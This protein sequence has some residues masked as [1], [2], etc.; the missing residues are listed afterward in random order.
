MK[1][2]NSSSSNLA[3][4][5]KGNASTSSMASGNVEPG[6]TRD[7]ALKVISKKKVK[8]NEDAVWGEMN[9]LKGLDHRNIVSVFSSV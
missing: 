1:T 3:P 6:E 9:V 4:R 7:V 8:G 5:H 2:G